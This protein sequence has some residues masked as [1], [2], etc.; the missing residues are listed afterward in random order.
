MQ[1]TF[2]EGRLIYW[3]HV[4]REIEA[5]EHILKSKVLPIIWKIRIWQSWDWNI[6][7]MW[8]GFFLDWYQWQKTVFWGFT[9]FWEGFL[10]KFL[11]FERHTKGTRWISEAK[12]GMSSRTRKS[13]VGILNQN[14]L[15]CNLEC[16]YS[17][18]L[19]S[20]LVAYAA[21]T[22]NQ[23]PKNWKPNCIYVSQKYR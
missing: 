2:K 9:E 14:P 5:N 13:Q 12:K 8:W 7:S 20:V 11:I 16:S 4:T 17:I 19:S 23:K 6:P 1:D 18:T 21:Q 15:Y 10:K 22:P 3:S